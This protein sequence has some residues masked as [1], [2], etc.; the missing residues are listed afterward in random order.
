M[1]LGHDACLSPP[2][3]REHF[4]FWGRN[5]V[6]CLTRGVSHLFFSGKVHEAG[7]KK[8]KKK[9]V[10]ATFLLV[11]T[12]CPFV[13]H[14]P[15]SNTVGPYTK[16]RWP[17]TDEASTMIIIRH[18]KSRHMAN[19]MPQTPLGGA[20]VVWSQETDKSQARGRKGVH[21]FVFKRR[22]YLIKL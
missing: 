20:G 19:A 8:R 7:Q 11:T 13:H 22:V 10:L 21:V 15:E 6:S 5:A 9:D 14:P 16:R 18:A 17:N 12:K 2:R 1:H 3:I 4:D